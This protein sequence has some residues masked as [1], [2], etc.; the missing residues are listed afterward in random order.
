MKMIELRRGPD[1][2]Y[3]GDHALAACDGQHM[4]DLAIAHKRHLIIPVDLHTTQ[5]S[6]GRARC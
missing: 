5:Y 4:E 6:A 2:V 3:V 1:R